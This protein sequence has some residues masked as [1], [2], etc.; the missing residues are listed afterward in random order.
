ME[1]APSSESLGE[2]ENDGGSNL[3]VFEF[4]FS[5]GD[6]VGGKVVFA[7]VSVQVRLSIFFA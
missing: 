4:S 1:P 3:L 6:R 5:C 2:W 7:F